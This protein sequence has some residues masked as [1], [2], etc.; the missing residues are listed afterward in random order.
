MSNT[1][2]QL[3]KKDFIKGK[4]T[5]VNLLGYSK[6]LNFAKNLKNKIVKDLKKY[7]RRSDSLLQSVEFILERKL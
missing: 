7:G 6:A 3:T 2:Q 5:L 1:E 4:A